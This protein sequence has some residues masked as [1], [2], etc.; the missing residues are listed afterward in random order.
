MA[1]RVCPFCGDLN[2]RGANVC[3]FCK[4]NLPKLRSAVP[5]PSLVENE[6]FFP[7]WETIDPLP[8]KKEKPLPKLVRQKPI[9]RKPVVNKILRINDGKC[10]SCGTLLLSSF[11]CL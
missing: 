7:L 5:E 3:V 6:P 9:P 10:A 11:V 2:E 8:E 1:E 4:R